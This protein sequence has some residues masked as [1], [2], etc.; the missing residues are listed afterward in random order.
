MRVAHDSEVFNLAVLARRPEIAG[1]FKT[2]ELSDL[3]AQFE[4][5]VD[6]RMQML[7][8]ATGDHQNVTEGLVDETLTALRSGK[9][10]AGNLGEKA[11]AASL[12]VVYLTHANEVLDRVGVLLTQQ[13][14]A[15]IREV[16]RTAVFPHLDGRIR[17][18]VA[19]AT[20]AA[21]AVGG[22]RSYDEAAAE[23]NR[24]A[25][26]VLD[27]A[28]RDYTGLRETQ[29]L[30][31]TNAEVLSAFRVDGRLGLVNNPHTLFADVPAVQ[32]DWAFLG[33]RRTASGD[34]ERVFWPWPE[35]VDTIEHFKWVVTNADAAKP[36][37]PDPATVEKHVKRLQDNRPSANERAQRLKD[38]TY[39]QVYNDP[40]SGRVVVPRRLLPQP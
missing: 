21:S 8:T 34:I 13:Q 14:T 25:W 32:P 3:D 26:N 40:A 10:P 12:R 33:T 2:V 4:R 39:P 18:V 38:T 35:P 5:L 37:V 9:K 6:A 15:V 23:G 31:Y 29:N 1:L 27:A 24:D 7:K 16:L 30:L 19:G 17:A 36:W 22:A 11:H 28:W 20:D